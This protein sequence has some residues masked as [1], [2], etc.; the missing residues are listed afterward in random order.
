MKKSVF[1]LILICIF[2]NTY[3]QKTSTM[4]DPRD[5]QKYQIVLVGNDWWMAKNLNYETP[6]G[7]AYYNNNDSLGKK[8]GRLYTWDVATTACPIGWH[9]PTL[10]EMKI[11]MNYVLQFDTNVYEALTNPSTGIGLNF[12]LGGYCQI[13]GSEPLG[14]VNSGKIGHYWLNSV[15]EKNKNQAYLLAVF[16]DKSVKDI[17]FGYFNCIRYLAYFKSEQ[18]S[19]RCKKN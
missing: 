19:V 17:R 2:S 8:Y 10:D 13:N 9:L 4:T 5:G 1:I 11:L 14:F 12:Q 16:K 15:Y 18:L 3:S 6:S 7:C